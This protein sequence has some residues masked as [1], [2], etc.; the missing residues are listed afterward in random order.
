MTCTFPHRTSG[1]RRG[2]RG[3]ALIELAIALP[4]LV[5]IL[6][7]TVDFARVFRTA[8][9]LTNAARAG[10]QY[11]SLGAAQ[12]ADTAGM[13]AAATNA[14]P[15][16]PGITV[17]AS[18]LCQCASNQGNFSPTSPANNCADTCPGGN[19]SNH[20]VVTVSVT[21]TSTFT[22]LTAFPG[23]PSSITVSRTAASRVPQ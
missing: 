5:L 10:V 22:T 19:P 17:T 9:E 16:V 21:A 11:G 2:E 3:A 1:E 6:M 13:Q 18:R 15:D 7:G 20:L 14:A 23:I 12:S 8:I 4:M